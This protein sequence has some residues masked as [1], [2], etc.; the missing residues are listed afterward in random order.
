MTHSM[1]IASQLNFA[2]EVFLFFTFDPIFAESSV[3]YFNVCSF[4]QIKKQLKIKIMELPA[5]STASP[6]TKL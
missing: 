5:P 2:A 3:F 6:G 4:K 1:I